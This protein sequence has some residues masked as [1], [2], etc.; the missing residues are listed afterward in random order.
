M[1]RSSS[2]SSLTYTK[3]RKIIGALDYL[4]SLVCLIQKW[5]QNGQDY[6]VCL[7][8]YAKYLQFWLARNTEWRVEFATAKSL[9]STHHH[10]VR[11]HKTGLRP[12]QL[13]FGFMSGVF[14]G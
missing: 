12:N 11:G 6:G 1:R 10:N 8:Y 2:L 14:G 5:Y 13:S 4:N 9:L 7:N 3:L